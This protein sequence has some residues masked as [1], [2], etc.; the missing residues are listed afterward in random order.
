[1]STKALARTG[2]MMPALFDEFFRPWNDWFDGGRSGVI[3]LP[4]VNI[5]ELKDAYEVSLAAPGLKKEDLTGCSS[6]KK[7]LSASLEKKSRFTF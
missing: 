7:L 6:L 2:G 4:A 3:N 1:M 5:T